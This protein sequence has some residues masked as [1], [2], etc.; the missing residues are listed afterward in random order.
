METINYCQ[1]EL[2]YTSIPLELYNNLN[3]LGLI[4]NDVREANVG[5]SNYAKHIIQPWSI[6]IDYDLNPWDADI[7][8]RILRTKEEEGMSLK[9]SRL[10]DYE[11]II[12]ICKE[13]IR[14]LNNGSSE[15]VSAE[16]TAELS[17]ST[18]DGVYTTSIDTSCLGELS[19][20]N[21][22]RYRIACGDPKPEI[23]Y[24]LK[25]SEIEA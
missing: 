3:K 14:Q 9:E 25:G 8:K 22:S 2:N 1:S 23:K 21:P 19:I 10:M 24:V 18:E 15:D 13:R 7:V 5:K 17:I 16:S 6:W 12:H 4:P 20:P 11:K